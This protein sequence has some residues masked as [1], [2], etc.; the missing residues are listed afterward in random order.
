M[1]YP[2]VLN[3]VT[4]SPTLTGSK[5]A[6]YVDTPM[7]SKSSSLMGNYGGKMMDSRLREKGM[8]DVV[9]EG[10]NALER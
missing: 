3:K 7:A 2:K 10:G 8:V 6:D 1:P 4:P 9:N 5:I